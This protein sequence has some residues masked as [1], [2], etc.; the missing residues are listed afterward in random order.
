MYRKHSKPSDTLVVV[1]PGQ[2]YKMDAPV[3]WYS[4]AAAIEAGMDVL[5]I[6]YSFQVDGASA[7]ES[8]LTVVVEEVADAL[9]LFLEK[10][11][12]GRLIFVAKSIGTEIVTE[13]LQ[14]VD[15]VPSHYVFLTPL[16]STL[17][18]IN[19]TGNMLVIVGDRDPV[20]STEN[21]RQICD[22]QKVMVAK[23]AN[24]I[25]E[26]PGNLAGSLDILKNVS[27][28]LKNYFS[29]VSKP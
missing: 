19:K 9:R 4:S 7:Q 17:Q 24:H 6:E 8:T 25:L 15:F 27:M 14:Y 10:H 23:D 29:S 1:F 16:R 26:I 18:F 13:V 5:G 20:F 21:V 22:Q 11:K 12:Y 28:E 2:A 3:M